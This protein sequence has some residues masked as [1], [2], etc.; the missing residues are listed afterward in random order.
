MDV[1]DLVYAGSYYDREDLA[2]NDYSDYVEYASFGAWVQQHACEDFYWYGFTGCSDPSVYFDSLDNSSRQ[3]HEIRLS[4]KVDSG[5]PLNW[6][7]GAYYEKNE[8]DGYLNWV[9]PTS[10]L[11]QVLRSITTPLRV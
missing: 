9:M 11:I 7:I 1:G 4:S 5:S 8:Y 3:S 2:T 6:I 10:I